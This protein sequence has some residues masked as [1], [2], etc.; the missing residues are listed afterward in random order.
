MSLRGRSAVGVVR[1]ARMPTPF[2]PCVRPLEYNVVALVEQAGAKNGDVL[3]ISS[4]VWE[5]QDVIPIALAVAAAIA[6]GA[7]DPPLLKKTWY[8]IAEAGPSCTRR[9]GG[10]N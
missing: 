10:R 7:P 1:I 8:E 4:V 2:R 9:A 3:S 6:S 5:V